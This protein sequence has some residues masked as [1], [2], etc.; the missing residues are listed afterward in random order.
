MEKPRFSG[1]FSMPEKKNGKSF[2]KGVAHP[3]E[4][5]YSRRHQPGDTGTM[6]ENPIEESRNHNAQS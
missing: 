6:I 3:F 5:M 1:V 4:G 2:I